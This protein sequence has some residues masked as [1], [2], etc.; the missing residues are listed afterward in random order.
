MLGF[1]LETA[2]SHERSV[3]NVSRR[4]GF[5]LDC[6]FFDKESAKVKNQIGL[7]SILVEELCGAIMLTRRLR[8]GFCWKLIR[9][10]ADPTVFDICEECSK[11]RKAKLYAEQE[12]ERERRIA[13]HIMLGDL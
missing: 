7:R 12:Q 9:N 11:E 8:C 2:S 10:G 5:G 1:E 3:Y 6:E 13:Q 4:L